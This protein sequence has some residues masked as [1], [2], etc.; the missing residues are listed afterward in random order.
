MLVNILFGVLAS[1]GQIL[2]QMLRAHPTPVV[3]PKM[4]VAI[5][6]ILIRTNALVNLKILLTSPCSFRADGNQMMLVKASYQR[7]CFTQPFFKRRQSLFAK[8]SRFI[9]N[10]PRHNCW[11]VNISFSRV[12]VRAANDEL[13]IV[14]KQLVRFRVRSI[15]GN[16]FHVS[17]IAVFVWAGSLSCTSMFQIE[18]ISPTPFPR[19]IQIEHGHHVAFSHFHEQIVKAG[20]DS[21][22]I[23][24]WCHLQRGFNLG[25]HTSFAIASHQDAKIVN[26]HAFHQVEFAFQALAVATLPF[27]T[28]YGTI[29]KVGSYIIIRFASTHEMA[30]FHFHKIVL[31]QC[32]NNHHGRKQQHE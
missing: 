5:I 24:A 2:N 1:H 26:P 30:I 13:H 25:G 3:R 16:K 21:V 10:L 12:A 32:W 14:I 17:R 27:R 22:V 9:T 23:D 29:P 20:K 7:R 8:C 15:L 31:S 28:Q 6:H 18:A 4:N 19:V 11:V